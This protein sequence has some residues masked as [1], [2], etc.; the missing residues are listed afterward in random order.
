M[1]FEAAEIDK[2][3]EQKVIEPTQTKWAATIV[4]IPREE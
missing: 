3:L 1:E 2:I 4:S